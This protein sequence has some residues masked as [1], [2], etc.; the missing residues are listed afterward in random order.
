LSLESRKS[1][2]LQ[3]PG[4]EMLE[5]VTS[6]WDRYGRIALGVL[7][8]LVVIGVVAFYTVRQNAA[9]DN[10]ASGKLL[11]ADRLFLQGDLERAKTVAEDVSRTYGSTPSGNDAHRLAGDAAYWL[12]D[13]KDAIS[14][15]QAYLAKNGKG[16][17]ADCVRRSLAYTYDCNAQYADAARIYD[18]LVGAFDRESS[19]EM[20]AASA[21]CFVALGNKPE[22]IKRLQR[23]IDEYG[24]TSYANPARERLAEL[25]GAAI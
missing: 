19:G 4:A 22:A 15:Y 9:Q 18:G 2:A 14:N 13:W 6:L 16:L 3:D 5:Q 24:D 12:R 8:A 1:T 7:G 21:R 11:E 25:G 17:L 20:L 10:V 23:L